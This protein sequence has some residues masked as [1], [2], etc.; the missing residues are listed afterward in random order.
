[1]SNNPTPLHHLKNIEEIYGIGNRHSPIVVENFGWWVVMSNN[2]VII[3]S[4][5]G[6]LGNPKAE[7]YIVDEQTLNDEDWL[8]HLRRKGWFTSECENDFN[9]AIIFAK[10]KQRIKCTLYE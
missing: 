8:P 5:E 10:W 6:Y 9:K 7:P 3:V 1:M 4:K 2:D